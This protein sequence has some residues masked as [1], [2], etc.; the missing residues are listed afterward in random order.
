MFKLPIMTLTLTLTLLGCE[1]TTGTNAAAADAADDT[2]ASDVSGNTADSADGAGVDSV[3]TVDATADG[4]APNDASGDTAADGAV[5][6][7]CAQKAFLLNVA[8]GVGAGA[9]YA[10]ATL[11]G[12]CAET[13]F[14]LT[15]NGMPFYTFV[16]MTPNALKTVNQ[17][18]T[19]PR[20]P[21]IAAKTT[22]VPLV[23]VA[24]FTVSGLPFF[25]PTEATEPADQI[26]GDPVY[27][28]LM[29]GC[30]GHTSPGEY[31]N[32]ALLVKCLTAAA[33][34][35]AEPWT[36]P[37]PAATEA[38]PVIGWAM[39]GFPVYGPYGCVDAACKQV[40]EMK[41]GYVKTSDPKTYAWKAY[42]YT[43][44]PSDPTVLDACNGRIGPDGTYRYH[45][46]SGFPYIIGCF[47][48]T[49]ASSTGG[50]SGGGGGGGPASCTT[51]TDCT[52]K[53]AAGSK[54]CGCTAV[55][56]GALGCI[57]T[58]TSDND[59]GSTPDGKKTTC[60]QSFCK[61]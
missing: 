44:V 14:T 60:K 41:S 50:N 34:K 19:V 49:P 30:M 36:L 5:T 13:T 35:V 56:G 42:T 38:S 6:D 21:A 2:T 16:A 8:S 40:A 12:S 9:G 20:H 26:Y 32:H 10:K 7:D 61:P 59:C 18:W 17:S 43:A 28:G 58:C 23:G 53:C 33:L 22:E 31:H 25:G 29:D 48:G 37:D 45:A 46:T 11:A 15:S 4:A 47:K 51:S 1:Q 52:G 39:D 27:N 54:G 3:A 55:A 24:G 57:P